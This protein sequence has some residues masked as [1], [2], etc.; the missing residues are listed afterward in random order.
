MRVGVAID[1]E[2]GFM[3][4]PRGVMEGR[5][6]AKLLRDLARLAEEENIARFV[7]GLPLDM[8]GGKGRPR[9]RRGGS[10]RRSRT[11]PGAKWSFWMSA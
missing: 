9:A 11:R 4:H 7:I 8:K 6:R 5:D 3:A 10:R 2:L 1:D